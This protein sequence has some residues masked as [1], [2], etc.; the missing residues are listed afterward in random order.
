MDFIGM[1]EIKID[2]LRNERVDIKITA[3]LNKCPREFFLIK[4]VTKI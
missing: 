4:Q 2:E 3:H 1:P